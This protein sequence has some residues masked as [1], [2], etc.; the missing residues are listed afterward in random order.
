MVRNANGQFVK[1][2]EKTGGRKKRP[3][4]VAYFDAFKDNVT[5]EELG[6]IARIVSD[7][8]KR[9]NLAAAKIV[10]DYLLGLPVQRTEITG[11][12]GNAIKI[13]VTVKDA[14]L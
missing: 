7:K 11:K 10:F 6:E 14:G 2:H 8:A 9:G 1:G 13:K 3:A 12:D 5:P 4:E